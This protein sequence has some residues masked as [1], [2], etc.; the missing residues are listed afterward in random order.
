MVVSTKLARVLFSR[1]AMLSIQ[2]IRSLSIRTEIVV[3]P[4]S[5]AFCGLLMSHLTTQPQERQHTYSQ[6]YLRIS[7]YPLCIYGIL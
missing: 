5:G 1:F 4:R 7:L 3:L 2:A 6:W